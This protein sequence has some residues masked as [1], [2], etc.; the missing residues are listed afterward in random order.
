MIAKEGI[1]LIV[2]SFSI[3]IITLGLWR[4]FHHPVLF[5]LLILIGVF[6]FFNLFF[7]RDPNRNVP[8]NDRAILA[9]ADGKIVQ[10]IQVDEPR[11]FKTSVHQ[12]SIF[13]SVF[14]VH[15]NR[16]PISGQVDAFSYF[17]GKFLAAFN[18]KASMVNEQTAIGIMDD[19]GH[20]ILFKQIAGVIARRIVCHLREGDRVRAGQRMGMIR[21]GSRVDV[22]FPLE[23]RVHVRKG[24]KVFAGETILATFPEDGEKSLL[25]ETIVEMPGVEF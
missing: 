15:V 13:L 4:Y 17:P 10:V 16:V 9:P 24:Q 22:L 11:Y 8:Q 21:Y 18:H 23:A 6:S 19:R 14:D 7:F 3:F 20:R 2:G 12:V 25:E 1:G 5:V